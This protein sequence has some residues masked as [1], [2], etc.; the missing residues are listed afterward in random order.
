MKDSERKKEK[1]GTRE[2]RGLKG[3]QTEK[4]G[5]NDGMEWNGMEGTEMD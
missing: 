4:N 5:I 1:Q 2:R 3:N